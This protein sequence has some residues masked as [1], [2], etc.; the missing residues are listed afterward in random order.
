VVP[1]TP[2]AA[3]HGHSA[4]ANMKSKLKKENISSRL[5]EEI[6]EFVSRIDEIENRTHLYVNHV[7]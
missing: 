5:A 1:R 2:S 6:V 7:R 3:T 4:S